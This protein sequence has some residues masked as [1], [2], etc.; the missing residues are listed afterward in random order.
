MCQKF[1][2][3]FTTKYY[4]GQQMNK[5]RGKNM[6]EI[7]IKLSLHLWLKPHY[8]HLLV[9]I[10]NSANKGNFL[11]KKICFVLKT[12]IFSERILYQGLHIKG[13]NFKNKLNKIYFL[14]LAALS[15]WS[16]WLY[17]GFYSVQSRNFRHPVSG[18]A[19]DPTQPPF[20][21]SYYGGK[22]T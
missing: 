13:E 3:G 10:C 16:D 19:L 2:R 20:G 6:S 14:G 7:W 5:K 1:T 12:P 4:C 9:I 17:D 22:E 8:I 15:L 11:F 18:P 21:D